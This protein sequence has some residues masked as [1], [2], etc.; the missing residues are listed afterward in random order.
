MH[1]AHEGAGYLPVSS[2]SPVSTIFPSFHSICTSSNPPQARSP[3][4]FPEGQASGNAGSRSTAPSAHCSNISSYPRCTTEIT[5]DLERWMTHRRG[6]CRVPPPSR[7]RPTGV[8]WFLIELVSMIAIPHSRPPVDLP[9]HA[10]TC[11]N[12]RSLDQ[13]VS[14]GAVQSGCT[15]SRYLVGRKEPIQM[16]DMTVMIIRIIDIIQPLLQLSMF[17]YLHGRKSF[18]HFCKRIAQ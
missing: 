3:A 16:G 6:Y 8:S 7:F 15:E 9:T 2:G 17:S 12:I 5:I 18:T 11:R 10:P 1:W 4:T 13:G 14:G